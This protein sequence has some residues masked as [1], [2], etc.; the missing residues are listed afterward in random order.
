MLRPT[1]PTATPDEARL[2]VLLSDV[3]R[4]IRQDFAIRA[5]GTALTP[6]LWRLLF[7]VARNEGGRQTDF[8]ERLDLTTVTVG[9][10]IDRLEK[11]QL[12]RRVADPQDRRASR[13]YL[14]R[15]AAPM[16]ERLHEIAR[17][18]NAR[19]TAGLDAATLEALLT[20]LA[21]V[22]YN[23]QDPGLAPAEPPQAGG[24]DGR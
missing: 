14:G 24:D 22:R 8:A 9:R 5:A 11:Q 4:L 10:M 23:L 6:A 3:L 17:G 1:D 15:R 21:H 12:V 18:T 19:A 2:G 20:T 16:V 7:H 13:V